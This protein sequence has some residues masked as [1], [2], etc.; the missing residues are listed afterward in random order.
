MHPPFAVDAKTP[1]QGN[2]KGRPPLGGRPFLGSSDLRGESYASQLTTTSPRASPGAPGLHRSRPGPPL[3]KSGL[4]FPNSRSLPFW[5]RIVSRPLPPC[6]RSFCA[7]PWMESFPSWPAT[8][9]A[10]AP[11]AIWSAA[12]PPKIVSSPAL[13]WMWSGPPRPQSA[14]ALSSPVMLSAN[15]EPFT[16]WMLARVSL[17]SPDAVPVTRLTWT[18]TPPAPAEA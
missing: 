3:R 15:E 6:R 18:P 10:P 11:E 16:F 5:P 12:A 9:S 8:L 7:P 13:P 1:A 2:K 4:A 14:L 17:P